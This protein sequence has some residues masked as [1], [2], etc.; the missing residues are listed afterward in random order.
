MDAALRI[1]R[2]LKKVSKSFHLNLALMSPALRWPHESLNCTAR[3]A[4]SRT[5]HPAA[6]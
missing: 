2:A 5:R 6:A 1:L 3:P 4:W